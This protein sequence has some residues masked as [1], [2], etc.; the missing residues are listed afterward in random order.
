MTRI[1][2]LK[3][4]RLIRALITTRLRTKPK[5]PLS[6]GKAGSFPFP[7]SSL[8]V[9]SK[10]THLTKLYIGMYRIY[11][12]KLAT[13]SNKR[14]S[15]W[16]ENLI[17]AHVPR[18]PPRPP[19]HHPPPPPLQQQQQ[20]QQL[21]PFLLLWSYDPFAD[22]LRCDTSMRQYAPENSLNDLTD[23]EIEID[24]VQCYQ[25]IS[26]KTEFIEQLKFC[27]STSSHFAIFFTYF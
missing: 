22:M 17:S 21:L 10:I 15:L 25:E 8:L 16:E 3:T 24:L 14:P 26:P 12:I 6:M 1:E 18:P 4:A 19:L 2:P 27:S 20:Q 5:R 7:Y 13:T 9:S 11:S 23:N